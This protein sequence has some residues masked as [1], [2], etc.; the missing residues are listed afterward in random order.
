MPSFF[1]S[2][3]FFYSYP[4]MKIKPHKILKEPSNYT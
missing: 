3:P 4:M 1:N 2:K